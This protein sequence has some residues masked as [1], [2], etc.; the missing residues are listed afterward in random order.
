MLN[1][2]TVVDQEGPL[3]AQAGPPDLQYD[4]VAPVG[5]GTAADD[6]AVATVQEV[7]QAMICKPM[8]TPIIRGPPRSRRAKTPVSIGSLRRS[9]RLA[10]RPRAAN[11]TR[12]AQI[13][14]MKK[15]GMAVD[16]TDADSDIDL[17][18]RA[19]FSGPISAR[20]QQALQIIFSGDFDPTALGLD[21]G[22]LDAV[23]A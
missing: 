9:R 1:A 6:G 22:D 12:Q 23:E 11:S 20:K 19:A 21:E 7:L 5:S 3:G 13:V 4:G 10:A 14:L 17:K 2:L 16:A 8:Q 15:L 18:F